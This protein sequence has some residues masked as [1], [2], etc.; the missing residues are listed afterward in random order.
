MVA[1]VSAN[2][3]GSLDR[4]IEMI[5]T[6]KACGADVVK[7][8]VYTP[9]SLTIDVDNRYFR[10]DHP[11][12][13][14]QTLYELY[15]K[16]HTPFEWLPRLKDVCDETGIAFLCTAFDKRGVDLLEELGVGA[17]KIAS[18]E[19]VDLSL[20]AYAAGTGKPL[21]LSTGMSTLAEIQDAVDAAKASGAEQITLL[22]CISSYPAQPSEMNLATIPHMAALFG[23]PVGLSDHSLGIAAAVAAVSLGARMVEKHFVLS[24]TIESADNFFS[25]EPGELEELVQSVRIAEKAVGRVRYGVT[26]NEMSSRVFRRSLFIVKDMQAGEV[27]SE[28]NVRSIRPGHGLSPKHF[29]DVRGRKARCHLEKGTPLQWDVI[30]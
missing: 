7:F 15:S 3:G 12:W 9:D 19:L 26:E 24:R 6:A 22:K 27:F 5:R 8:Q 17:H 4:A 25:I 21:I 18:F 11:K 1:E 30:A 20:V 2:H 14:G 16:A 28:D 13:G 23:C 10:V 29:Q